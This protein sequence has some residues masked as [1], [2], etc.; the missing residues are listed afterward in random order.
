MIGAGLGGLATAAFLAKAG[1]KTTVFEKTSYIGG[2]C[3]SVWFGNSELGKYL[4]DVGPIF[5]GNNLI[6]LIKKRLK[7][8]P[9]FKSASVKIHIFSK[10]KY[11]TSIPPGRHILRNFRKMGLSFYET[12]SLIYK[13]WKQKHF[14]SYSYMDSHNDIA[15]FLTKNQLMRN[16]LNMRSALFHG[17]L[18]DDMPGYTFNNKDYGKPFYPMGG[19]QK[20]PDT[21]VNIIKKYNGEIY[22]NIPVERISIEDEKAVGVLAKGERVKSDFIISGVSVMQTVLKLCKGINFTF[23]FSDQI[24]S[25]K[26]GLQVSMIFIIIDKN[27]IDVEGGNVLYVSLPASDLNEMVHQLFNGIYPDDLPFGLFLPQ[28]N[29]QDFRTAILLFCASKGETNRERIIQEG[30]R[31]LERANLLISNFT[32]SIVWK[33]NV[34]SLDYPVEIGFRSCVLPVAESKTYRKLSFQLPVKNLFNVGSSV[35]PAGG[36]TVQAVKSGL[37]CAE[38]I[39]KNIKN[40]WS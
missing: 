2:R 35:L 8:E 34:T 11:L 28:E 37:Q 39:I 13:L 21:F 23:T 14:E 27:R 6:K 3:R 25:F 26:Q 19:I 22:T 9:A 12:I 20:I 33:K 24:K 10:G 16:I 40:H 5:S 15:C 31:L 38:F 4:F 7:E 30:E 17:C 1:L 36:G 32:N 29:Q 18:P